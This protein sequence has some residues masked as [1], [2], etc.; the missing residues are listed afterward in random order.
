KY[1]KTV[2]NHPTAWPQEQRSRVR[3][4]I[5]KRM[6]D[7]AVHHAEEP[8]E[9]LPFMPFPPAKPKPLKP[10]AEE[11]FRRSLELATNLLETHEAL[12]GYYLISGQ[13]AK[14]EQARRDLLAHFPQDVKTLEI[15]AGMCLARKDY[16]E[17]LR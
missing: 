2:A 10:S 17:M 13:L 1:E 15:L 11:C 16:P 14:A 6:G 4:L 12:A 9:D 5:W 3:A 7:N 8:G